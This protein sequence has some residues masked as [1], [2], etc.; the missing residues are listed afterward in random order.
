[1]AGETLNVPEHDLISQRPLEP[2]LLNAARRLPYLLRYP[3]LQRAARPLP[4]LR[5]LLHL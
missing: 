5:L 4:N 1:M 2:P 3:P